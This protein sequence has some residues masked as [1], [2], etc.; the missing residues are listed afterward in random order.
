M[1]VDIQMWRFRIGNFVQPRKC[2]SALNKLYV[3]GKAVFGLVRM[4]LVF[5][6]LLMLCGDV[7]SNPGPPKQVRQSD[8]VATRQ[9]TISFSADRRA[10]VEPMRGPV[11]SLFPERTH[12]RSQSELFTFLTQ[13][14]EDLST[15]NKCVMNEV[16]SINTKIDDLTERV[17]NLK[18]ENEKLKKSNNSLKTQLSLVATKLDYLEGQSRRNNLRFNGLHGKSDENWDVTEEKVRSF[19]KNDMEMPE[20]ESVEIE[21][22][23]R[24][25]SRD[26]NKCTII[27]KFTKF[28]DRQNIL[29]RAGE[30]FDSKSAFS[31]QADYTQRVKKHRRELGKKMIAARDAGQE[32]RVTFDKLIIGNKLYRYDDET[33]SVILVRDKSKPTR[34]GP[35]GSLYMGS[36]DYMRQQLSSNHSDSGSVNDDDDHVDDSARNGNETMGGAVGGADGDERDEY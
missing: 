28:K 1:G 14:K 30:V 13:M 10:S 12:D 3:S 5:S 22:A 4:T 8:R 35:H 19:I 23:H 36:A 32:A 20:Y 15:Q 27:V 31:V 34:V 6:L 21:R 17:K 11:G 2:R 26:R 24:L 9:S 18:T 25:K 7:E 16:K 29:R 33:E